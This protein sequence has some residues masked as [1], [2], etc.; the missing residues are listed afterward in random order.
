MKMAREILAGLLLTVLLVGCG[1]GGGGGGDGV[2]APSSDATLAG[3][4]LS[5]GSLDQVFQSLQSDY[6]ATVGFLSTATTVTP[7]LSDAAAV[8]VNGADVASGDASA[9]IPLVVGENTITVIVTAEDG[10]TTGTYTLTV[11]RESADA[12]AQQAYLKASN[13]GSGDQFGYSLALSGDTLAV[14][15]YR[16][17]SQA[18]GVNGDQSDNSRA[19]SGAVYVYTRSGTVW[20]QQAYLKA[21]N[22]GSGDEFGWSVALFGDTLAVGATGE[23]SQATGVNGDQDDDS[24]AEAGAVYVFVRS[25]TVWS[26]QAYLKASNTGSDDTFGYTVALSGDTLAVGADREA[27]QATGID[28]DQGDDS[29]VEAAV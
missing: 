1:G 21:S 25:G 12:F 29:L 18:T 20:S 11:T 15:A 27:S 13:T 6:T 26:Q 10:V 5:A 23:A 7:V 28:G 3:L 22:T 2:A 17:D 16:E 4:E 19:D 8:S 14:G 24:L 9:P